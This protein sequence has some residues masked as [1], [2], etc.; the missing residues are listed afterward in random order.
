MHE[1]MGGEYDHR[2]YID[3]TLFRIHPV[4]GVL[5]PES[6][7]ISLELASALVEGLNEV[8]PWAQMNKE[9]EEQA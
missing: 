4:F 5:V 9:I 7:T 6:T 2:G 1:Q 3:I 8:A